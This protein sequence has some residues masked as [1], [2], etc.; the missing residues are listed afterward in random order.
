MRV[1]IAH[2]AC[3]DM[4]P[5]HWFPVKIRLEPAFP[6]S[7]KERGTTNL[8]VTLKLFREAQMG[9]SKKKEVTFFSL[10]KQ[11]TDYRTMEGEVSW[12]PGGSLQVGRVSP[13]GP[14]LVSLPRLQLAEHPRGT[15]FLSALPCPAPP[16]LVERKGLVRKPGVRPSTPV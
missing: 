14:R 7:Q 16:A 1:I 5:S 11:L 6:T 15:P 2:F 4:R 10:G 3:M 13:K 8:K 9:L 12:D